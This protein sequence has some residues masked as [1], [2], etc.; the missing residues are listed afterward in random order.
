MKFC[1]VKLL[2]KKLFVKVSLGIIKKRII[3]EIYTPE[4]VSEMGPKVDI[5]R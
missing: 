4:L 5:V 3:T 1:L 2:L